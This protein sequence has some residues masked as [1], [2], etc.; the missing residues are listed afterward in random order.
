M[1]HSKKKE[2][3]RNTCILPVV[4]FNAKRFQ[5]SMT[6]HLKYLS[7]F[8]ITSVVFL[9][10]LCSREQ[11]SPS[12]SSFPYYEGFEINNG[13]W[14]PGGTSSD[15]AWGTPSKPVISA[16]GSGTKCWIT[17]GLTTSFYNNGERS[18]LQS[19]CFDFTSLQHPYI[20]FKVFWETERVYDG[21]NLQYSL[22]LGA[23]WTNVGAVSDSIDCYNNNWFNYSPITGLSTLATIK[24]GWCGNIQQTSGSC[25]GGSG[26]GAWLPAKHTMPYLAG[27]PQVIFRFT[28]GAGTTCNNYDGFAIDDINITEAPAPAAAFTYN[29]IGSNTIG[30]INNSTTCATIFSWNFGDPASG[31]SNTSALANP[32]HTFS[33]PGM[34]N[35][36]LTVS[37]SGSATSI[38]NQQV[39]IIGL[40][41][42][43]ITPLLCFGDNNGSVAVTATGS[44][45]PYTYSWNTVPPQFTQII[46]GLTAGIYTV[47]VNALNACTATSSITLTQPPDLIIP[48]P[49]IVSPTCNGGTGTITVNPSGGTPPFQYSI[50]GGIIFQL[51]NTFIKP[52]GTYTIIVKDANGCSKTV[53]ATIPNP[54]LLIVPPPVVVNVSCNGGTGTI[55]VNPTGGIPPYQYSIDGGTTYQP[56]NN[57][58]E[59]A[60]TYMIMVKDANGCTKSVNATVTEP[61]AIIV[62]TPQITSPVCNGLTGTIMVNPSG[63]VPPY[64]YSINAGM[65]YQSSNTFTLVAGSYSIIVKDVKGCTKTV[66]TVITEPAALQHGISIVQP[67]CNGTVGSASILETG[68]TPGYNYSWSPSGGNAATANNLSPGNYITTITDTQGCLDTVHVTINPGH[69][70]PS[71]VISAMN[72]TSCFGG[73]NGSLTAQASGG[74]FPYSYTWNTI[75]VQTQQMA[76]GLPA[77]TYTVN[78]TDNYGCMATTIGQ[79][80]SPSAILANPQITNATCGLSNGSI[81]VIPSGGTPPYQF[82]WIPMISIS[83]I[84]SSISQGNYGV[85]IIDSN[86][87]NKVL[88]IPVINNGTPVNLFLGG[89]TALCLGDKLILSPGS[90]SQYLWQDNSGGPTLI[91]NSPGVYWVRVMNADG[92]IGADTILIRSPMN[93]SDIFFPNAFTPNG[94]M[95]NDRFGPL[96]LLSAVSQYRLNIFNR[97]GQLVFTSSDPSQKWSGD[98]DVRK[99]ANN[100]FAWYAR[101]NFKGV[102]RVQKGNVTLLR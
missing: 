57:F 27:Q 31:A 53:I 5:Q 96:G 11:C 102:S 65:S 76:T 67:G 70:F 98:V 82:V 45:G 39:T 93:C 1:H 7:G 100:T 97:W 56:G 91:V 26:S 43:V 81:Q 89:D 44:G 73:N 74:S 21:A 29:C 55:T 14:F 87:C 38:V 48:S 88:N 12:I 41:T 86:G 90:F 6:L 10:P 18:W 47:T 23:T 19:P 77:G 94:D 79:V 22:D 40:S 16:A 35:V 3:Y 34:Y 52:P 28:F 63:G 75:P 33:S 66:N 95:L 24:D 68:G 25:Q 69:P 42:S 2:E 15:W 46:S 78:I 17:G 9:C 71:V 80:N 85:T 101:Y 54:P 4:N 58:I 32:I 92:C 36:T 61:T 8:L 72:N 62:P 20:F 84:V 13:N 59:P 37:S 60:G 30:F 50:N 64:Q 51:S 99:I 49:L 83:G